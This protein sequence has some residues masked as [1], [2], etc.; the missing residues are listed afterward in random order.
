MCIC[1]ENDYECDGLCGKIISSNRDTFE[2]L[3]MSDKLECVEHCG[4]ATLMRV[5]VVD[6]E[7]FS[8][9][10]CLECATIL[11]YESDDRIVHLRSQ[12]R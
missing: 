2:L 10:V 6:G 1:T 11:G 5:H 7:D 3:T 8:F 12:E 4:P 9:P